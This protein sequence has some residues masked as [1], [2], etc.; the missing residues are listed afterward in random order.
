MVDVTEEMISR[1]RSI[2]RRTRD[3]PP[4]RQSRDARTLKRSHSHWARPPPCSIMPHAPPLTRRGRRKF[5][6]NSNGYGATRAMTNV[7]TESVC[8]RQCSVF[9]DIPRDHFRVADDSVANYFRHLPQIFNRGTA[10]G[11]IAR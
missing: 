2:D 5:H 1:A 3:L 11:A 7:L 6:G 4:S 8:G 10:R 9:P